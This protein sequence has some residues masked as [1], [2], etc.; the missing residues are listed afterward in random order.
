MNFCSV[1]SFPFC[2][3]CFAS[4]RFVSLRW[5][6]SS[7]VAF[8]Y[9][10]GH[11]ARI[12]KTAPTTIPIANRVHRN[13]FRNWNKLCLTEM[14]SIQFLQLFYVFM[15]F[16]CVCVLLK[17]SSL[18]TT[19]FV[20]GFWNICLFLHNIQLLFVYWPCAALCCWHNNGNLSSIFNF[21][22]HFTVLF[23]GCAPNAHRNTSQ[24][25]CQLIV[26]NWIYLMGILFFV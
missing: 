13:A 20:F 22:T 9:R 25:P 24:Y 8:D 3:A 5:C 10:H 14:T 16:M 11:L 18:G 17:T 1:F 26:S 23:V 19:K 6:R 15:F 21:R 12:I 4:L 2:F 7:V